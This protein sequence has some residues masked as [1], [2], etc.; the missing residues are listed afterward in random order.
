MLRSILSV[1]AASLVGFF[2]IAFIETVGHELYPPPETMDPTNA[3]SIK[4][5]MDQIPV[6]ALLINWFAY[7]AG[8]FVGGAVTAIL[9]RK[10]QI[11]AALICGVLL[12]LT[13]LLNLY[14]IPHPLWYSIGTTLSYIPFALIGA[15]SGKKIKDNN[16]I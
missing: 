7:I 13:G 1:I 8:A 4:A 10:N 3:E 6:A 2:V 9:C 12:M 5:H 11:I 14:L 15:N 16:I